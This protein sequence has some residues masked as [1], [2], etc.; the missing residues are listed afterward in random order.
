MARFSRSCLSKAKCKLYLIDWI[1]VQY[2][3]VFH[4][5]FK[6]HAY[7]TPDVNQDAQGTQTNAKQGEIK[8]TVHTHYS[9]CASYT[10]HRVQIR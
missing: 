9:H 7:S 4:N 3:S 10:V 5:F 8:Q 1:K 2:G 6:M